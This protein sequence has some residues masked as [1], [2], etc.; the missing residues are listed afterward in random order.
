MFVDPLAEQFM[1]WTPY[2]YVNQNPINL[3][4]PTGMSAEGPGDPPDEDEG[5]VLSEILINVNRADV[6]PK[7]QSLNLN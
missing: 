6:T 2:H 5:T 3:I 1:G 4:D 7:D